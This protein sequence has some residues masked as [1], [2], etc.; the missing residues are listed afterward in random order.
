MKY[1]TGSQPW[2]RQA[3]TM[4]DTLFGPLISFFKFLSLSFFFTYNHHHTS[5]MQPPQSKMWCHET[6]CRRIEMRTW[7]PIGKF[8]IHTILYTTLLANI[9]PRLFSLQIAQKSLTTFYVISSRWKAD[10][11]ECFF[12]LFFV[13][14]IT[15]ECFIDSINKI[16]SM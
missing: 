16:R 1:A 9:P 7:S 4:L 14:F 5:Q 11:G 6:T 8:F 10:V 13:F 15:K 2:R 3:Q 12:L